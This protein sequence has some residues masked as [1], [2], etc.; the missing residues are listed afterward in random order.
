MKKSFTL[1]LTATLAVGSITVAAGVANGRYNRVP[2]PAIEPSEQSVDR[3]AEVAKARAAFDQADKAPIH[4]AGGLTVILEVPFELE[5]TADDIS[6]FTIIDLN[7]NPGSSDKWYYNSNFKGLVS[8]ATKKHAEDDWAISPRIDI[9]DASK[10]YELSFDAYTNM[11][12]S[13]FAG[14]VEIYVGTSD[15]PADMTTKIG[16]LRNF[17]SPKRD[18]KVPFAMSFAVPAAGKYRIG[19]HCTTDPKEIE[20][21]WPV[22]FQKIA[23]KEKAGVVDAPQPVIGA[24]ATPA[25]QGAL[26]ATVNFVMPSKDLAGKDIPASEVLTATV[27]S[28]QGTTVTDTK[29]VTGAAGEAKSVELNTLQGDNVITITVAA[30]DKASE[31]AEVPVYTGV[32]LP[33]RVQNLKATVPE[34]NMS[35]TLTWDAPIAGKD[36]GYVDF[37]ALEYEIYKRD[38][39]GNYLFL[40]NVGKAKT[41]TYTV[42]PGSTLATV[43]L[44]VLAKNAAGTSDDVINWSYE[45]PVYVIETLGVPYSMPAVEK[46]D[47]L[48]ARYT[49]V[50]NDFP[51]DY[52]GKWFLANPS[53][54]VADDNQSALLAYN[55]L[56]DGE[57]W[58]RIRLPQFSTKGLNSATFTLKYLR[59]GSN[60][61]KMHV[62]ITAYGEE[63]EKLADLDC[64][65]YTDWKTETFPLPLKFQD[66]TWIQIVID[67]DL[68]DYYYMYGIDEY[69]FST[70]AQTDLA[71]TELNG[72]EHVPACS[73]ADFVAEVSN[74]GFTELNDA[75]VRFELLDGETVID[76]KTVEVGNMAMSEH[77]NVSAQFAPAAGYVNKR[78]AVRATLE[79]ASD[80]Q[81]GN[82]TATYWFNVVA[83]ESPV[84]TDLTGTS[85]NNS[86]TLNWSAP[87][88]AQAYTE[89]FEDVEPFAYEGKMGEFDTF[90]G[91]GQTVYQFNP[92]QNPMP[93]ENVAKAFLAVN[94]SELMNPEGLEAHTGT[95]YLMATCPEQTEAKPTP[96]RADDWL[97]SPE[98]PGNRL[99]SFWIN[100]I[101]VKYP[102]TIEIRTSKTGTKPENFT[103]TLKSMTIDR[104]GWQKVSLLLPKDARYFA[105]HYTSRDQFGILIDDITY[106]SMINPY[107]VSGYNVYRDGVKIG[108]TS[109]LT[110]IDTDVV[111]GHTYAY[112]IEALD[113]T[114]PYAMSAAM[115]IAHDNSAIEGVNAAAAAIHAVSGGIELSG[116][117][118]TQ[119]NVFDTLGRLAARVNVE[120]QTETVALPQGVYVVVTDGGLRVK[121]T[122]L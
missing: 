104:M 105:I 54:I 100:I 11:N 114:K 60:A 45:P 28:A 112:T 84:V 111:L 107:N 16:E 44:R 109:D 83:P 122:V 22:V 2:R 1:L 95:M 47:N 56:S 58:G 29:T 46:F 74:V 97:I 71:I 90:D 7:E 81:K 59:Y 68:D 88:L 89:S 18:V 12:I 117:A 69:S 8:P 50:R 49:P 21:P 118:G 80:G 48:E 63:L 85:L 67:V 61:S 79:S 77:R 96:D 9:T 113:G 30:G 39:A 78:L 62:Y 103:T 75:M 10:L 23:V 98:V 55:P 40:T 120:A 38:A 17:A 15:D 34:D 106:P 86:I 110:F 64:S 115:T 13:G 26:K 36:D 65:Q 57:T 35:M 87:S 93:N 121:V 51:D 32:V 94:H 37:D 66:R 42:E 27:K 3:A 43:A 70:G 116:L 119:V 73:N 91:D 19:F 92:S 99:I 82:N 102:E 6:Y 25:E 72:D 53:E 4:R 31:A 76:T 14:T 101:N 24:T 20:E 108:T 52:S 5:P 33:M 41:Y